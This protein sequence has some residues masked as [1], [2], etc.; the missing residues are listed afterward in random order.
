MESQFWQEKWSQPKRGWSQV[1]VNSRLIHHWPALNLGRDAAVLVPLCGDS[2]DID[3]LIAGGNRVTGSELVEAG[4][5]QWFRRHAL[6]WTRETLGDSATRKTVVRLQPETAE[7]Y[8]E[9]SDD[10]RNASARDATLV[11]HMPEFLCADFFDLRAEDFSLPMAAVYD[12]AALIALPKEMRQHY[13]DHLATLLET[14]AQI[15]LI[16]LNYAQEEMKGPPFSV[17]DQEVE[18]LY[19][20]GFDIKK[21]SGSEGPDIVGNLAE[22]G[23]SNAAESVFLMTRKKIAA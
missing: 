14:G 7:R 22:R 16:T 5:E 8:V 21:L 9:L 20:P 2:V 18:S 23:L 19:T 6:T 10:D 13:V 1:R 3:W 12:R 11:Q 4:L 17:S 15:L